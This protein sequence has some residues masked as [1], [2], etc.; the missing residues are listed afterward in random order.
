MKTKLHLLAFF[1]LFILQNG[2]SQYQPF[3]NN[4]SWN[5]K[6]FSFMGATDYII[7]SGTDV[8]I[9]SFTYKKINDP[10][11]GLD[12]YIREDVAAK[13]VY[14]RK[15]NVD[16]LLY[17]FSLPVSGT[18]VTPGGSMY[19]VTSITNVPVNG[20]GT[21][22]RFHLDNGFFGFNWIEGVG[23][24]EHPL[25]PD[26]EL[27]S[28]PAIMLYCS[29]QN[30]VLIYN[31][32]LADGNPPTDCSALGID[33]NN[34]AAAISF[35]PNPFTTELHINAS[36]DLE[37]VSLKLYNSVGQIVKQ[38]ENITL[39]DYALQRES[40][41]GGLYFLQLSRNNKVIVNKKIIIQ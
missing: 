24:P 1:L 37:N 14:T 15:N 3:L 21:R 23:N 11:S 29:A 20:G 33:E 35:S 34:L 17:D 10:M 7:N 28:D 39:L 32:G 16:E 9:G 19:T 13:K 31:K 40:L 2:H 4:S 12:I 27:P 30:G 22:K 25:R 8:V 41:S 5:V 38:V 6:V 18:F 36:F 26:Y